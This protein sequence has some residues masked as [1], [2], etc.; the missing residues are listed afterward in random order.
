MSLEGVDLF[1]D[2]PPQT[3]R[4]LPEPWGKAFTRQTHLS[5]ANTDQLPNF[6]ELLLCLNNLSLHCLTK[7]PFPIG[8]EK[9]KK[10]IRAGLDEENLSCHT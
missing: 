6:D 7:N 8:G 10:E 2:I 5:G 1:L 4:S 3:G 9:E